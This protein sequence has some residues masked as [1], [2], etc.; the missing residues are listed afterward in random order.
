MQNLLTKLRILINEVQVKKNSLLIFYRKKKK[1]FSKEIKK[2]FAY[3]ID[4]KKNLEALVK[5]EEFEE[6]MNEATAD[7]TDQKKKKFFF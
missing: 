7:L 4:K 5:L 1:I 6:E 3:I 2:N